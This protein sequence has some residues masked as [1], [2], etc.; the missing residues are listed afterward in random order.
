MPPIIGIDLG[1]TNSLV[2]HLVDGKPVLIG[3]PESGRLIVPSAISLL[4]GGSFLV[5]DTAR[6]LTQKSKSAAPA[7]C[8]IPH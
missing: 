3:E 1:T 7:I 8:E 2:G 4:P 6:E 5:G